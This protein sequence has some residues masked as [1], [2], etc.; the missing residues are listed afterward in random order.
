MLVVWDVV[1]GVPKKTIFDPHPKGVLALDVSF[2]GSLIVTLSK[3]EEPTNQVITLWKWE[4]GDPSFIK[5][6]LDPRID[7]LQRFI[8]FNEGQ[9][10][11]ATTGESRVVFLVL[12]KQGRKA[13]SSTH[14]TCRRK[15]SSRRQCS[16]PTLPRQ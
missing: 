11:F 4:E 16:S 7:C 3:E 6:S 5:T 1:T 8:K 12:G 14:L 9:N 15:G 10:E 13:S 2:D